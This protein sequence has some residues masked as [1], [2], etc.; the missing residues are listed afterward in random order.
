MIIIIFP[1]R[2]VGRIKEH[3]EVD[4]YDCI[5]SASRAPYVFQRI[6]LFLMALR[7]NFAMY[8]ESENYLV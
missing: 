2:V 7:Y 1:N 8:R 3:C 5:F 4:Y 6:W